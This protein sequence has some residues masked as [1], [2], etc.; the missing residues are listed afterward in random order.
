MKDWKI[1][2]GSDAHGNPIEGT[3]DKEGN[4]TCMSDMFQVG[5]MLATLHP[6]SAD[7]KEFAKCLMSKQWSAAQALE[8]PYML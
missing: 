4:Y 8:Q 1:G 2:S 3:L 6:T 7:G 5:V